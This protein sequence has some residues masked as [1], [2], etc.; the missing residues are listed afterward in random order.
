MLFCFLPFY[1]NFESIGTD[2]FADFPRR[3]D[4]AFPLWR[5]VQSALY[6][7]EK[8]S[9]NYTVT[10]KCNEQNKIIL[11]EKEM[12]VNEFNEFMGAVLFNLD[13]VKYKNLTYRPLISRFIRPGK[14]SYDNYDTFNY[15]S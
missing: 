1:H 4:Y 2:F 15:Y 3:N 10:R 14:Y 11:N 6:N 8:K 13:K 9:Y 5:T 7:C 12:S